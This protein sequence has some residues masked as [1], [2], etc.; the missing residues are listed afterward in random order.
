M[1][2]KKNYAYNV[3]YQLLKLVTPLISTPYLSRILTAEGVGYY[4][5]TYSV[6]NI[7]LLLAILGMENYG[8]RLIAAAGGDR[9]RRSKAFWGAYY[10]QAMIGTISLVAYIVFACMVES[11]YLPINLLWAPWIISAIFDVSWLFFGMQEFRMPALRSSVMKVLTLST[12]FFLVKSSDDLWIYVLITSCGT[13]AEQLSLWP[14]VSRQVDRCRPSGGEILRN[15]KPILSLFV[16]VIAINCY[17][18]FDKVLLGNMASIEQVGYFE[19]S[20]K[21]SRMPLTV[22]TALGTVALPKMSDVWERGTKE[23]AIK[24]IR[25]SFWLATAAAFAFMFGIAGVA[26]EFV[27]VFFGAGYDACVELM[28]VLSAIIPAISWTNVI[29]TQFLLPRYMD[30]TYTLSVALAAVVNISL[31]FL[32]IP[33]LDSLGTAIAMV[34]TEFTVLIVQLFAVKRELPVFK[35]IL[36]GAPALL[37]GIL[38]MLTLR[39]LAPAIVNVLGIG[40]WA[41][42]VEFLLGAA[43]YTTLFC[44]WNRATKNEMFYELVSKY[45]R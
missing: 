24:Y 11:A 13:L 5:Y 29:G 2:I 32:L 43:I 40:V 25:L 12:I 41:L 14:F 27:P 15:I 28:I 21:M 44:V 3:S 7:F 26:R 10:A 30:R 34:V 39:T 18:T 9:E 6:A 16:P 19:Y 17:T 38:M 4:S 36:S 8:V 22:I 1:S 31:N 20:E 37:C 45:L 42:V 35:L 33:K 23:Q